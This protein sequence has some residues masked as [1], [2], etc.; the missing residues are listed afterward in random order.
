[1]FN[2]TPSQRF[3]SDCKK[4]VILVANDMPLGSFHDFLLNVKGHMV[5]KMVKVQ[6]EE[7]AIAEQ[8]MQESCSSEG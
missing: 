7:E 2:Q 6:K 5:D 8:Q 1:M 4:A 3:E